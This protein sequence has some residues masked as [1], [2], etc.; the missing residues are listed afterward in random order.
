MS[1]CLSDE[2]LTAVVEAV[3]GATGPLDLARLAAARDHLAA[4]TACAAVLVALTGG[5]ESQ[6]AAWGV[7]D[8]GDAD[9]AALPGQ[10][11]DF[12]PLRLLG[13]G[14]MGAVYLATDVRLGRQV[15]LKFIRGPQAL[16]QRFLREAQALA[17]LQHPNVVMLYQVGEAQGVP[18]Q[19]SELVD[20]ED[21][22]RRARPVPP[23]EARR[24]GLQLSA[25]LAAAHARGIVH[26]D[27]K[28]SN[29]MLTR[30]G[31][32]KLVDFGLARLADP[33][34]G[35]ET[36]E[37]AL[38]GTP[39]YMAP[40]ALRGA[41]ATPASD[42]YS[43]GLL[44]WE[45]CRGS[46]P[47]AG[48]G[49]P[50]KG[51]I[52]GALGAIIDR[53]LEPEPAAR[54]ADAAALHAA[55][56]QPEAPR[57]LSPGR[58][59][60]ALVGLG[61]L[62]LLGV[63]LIGARAALPLL[64]PPSPAPPGMVALRGGLFTMGRSPAELD[65][66]CQRQGAG[67][68]RAQLDREQPRH[69]VRLSPFFL[70]QREVSADEFAFFLNSDL[71]QIEVRPDLDTHEP[72]WVT[73]RA[74]GGLGAGPVLL[75]DLGHGQP[76]LRYAVSSG[77]AARPGRG[78]WPA[79]QVTW[80]GAARY[81]QRQGRRLPTEAEWEF[82]A[83]GRSARRFPWGD[84]PPRCSGVIIGRAAGKPCEGPGVSPADV[85]SAAQ[86]VTPE[87]V[88]DLGGSATEWVADAFPQARYLPCEGCLDPLQQ[89][90]QA[91]EDLRLQRGGAW[92]NGL[93]IA[94]SSGRGRWP[95]QSTHTGAGF[96]CAAQ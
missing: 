72:R 64:R 61:L 29:V 89:P 68:L 2:T 11:G 20:G 24:I 31:Q 14:A 74:P 77:F 48:V 90:G 93:T 34:G 33:H 46:L 36:V 4:C 63:I 37:G 80:D 60:R 53:C 16:S 28:P 13:Q 49:P 23:P 17:R 62:G 86:D 59:R 76:L 30:E 15:A 84:E 39:R 85:G 44:L 21:L 5:R 25:G 57:W 27:I 78:R 81:C 58:S 42:I 65:L 26:R 87:G 92:D 88:R 18:Y 55:L 10:V 41:A 52:P 1:P 56:A 75:M 73:L 79:L 45:L 69:A 67:C 32:V 71:P 94:R 9:V 51:A 66:E 82:A 3:N 91:L 83:R 96:R 40:E 54:Y 19:V 8:A 47:P 38:I 50:P 95:R 70:D 35:A 7:L 12:R 22:G 6:G 43:V